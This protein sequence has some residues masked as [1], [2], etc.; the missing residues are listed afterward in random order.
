M[1]PP[2]HLETER[3]RSDMFNESVRPKEQVVNG[4]HTVSTEGTQP[5][6]YACAK[7]QDWTLTPPDIGVGWKRRCQLPLD[8]CLCGWGVCVG[9]EGGSN[10]KIQK[11]RLSFGGSRAHRLGV[12]PLRPPQRRGAG[13]HLGGRHGHPRRHSHALQRFH[14]RQPHAPLTLQADL[15]DQ[16]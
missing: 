2:L 9:G 13:L 12:V 6:L 14:R 3:N 5:V 4:I 16:E 7:V 15:C 8:L 10:L 11:Q 1:H